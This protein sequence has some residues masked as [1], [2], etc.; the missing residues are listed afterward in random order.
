MQGKIVMLIRDGDSSRYLFH[1]LSQDFDIDRVI[2]EN[3]ISQ[4][5]LLRGRIKRLGVAR[6]L[7]QV[8]F[9]ILVVPRLKKKSQNRIVALQDEY[10]LDG[11]SIDTE[12]SE[13]VPSVNSPECLRL[14]KDINPD[15]V[16]INGTRILKPN[17]LNGIDATFL[18]THAGITPQYRGVHGAYCRT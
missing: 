5:K 11:T 3:P 7:G 15:I 6:V 13:F 14:L 9:Q 17:I 18:N 12:K 10:Q 4:R 1:A 8:L 2:I 16:V